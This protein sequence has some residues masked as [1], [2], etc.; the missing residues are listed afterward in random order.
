VSEV[1]TRKSLQALVDAWLGQGNIAAGPTFVK[2]D[3]CMYQTLA[4]GESLALDGFVHP[5]NSIKEFFFPRNE[6]IYAYRFKGQKIELEDVDPPSTPRLIIGVR[7]CDAASMAILDRVFNW[8][9]KDKFYNVRREAATIVS[10]GCA[11][12]DANCFCTSVGLGPVAEKGSDAMLFPLGGDEFEVR[13]FAEKGKAL[14]A[15]KTQTSSKEFKAAAGPEARVDVEL[16]AAQLERN[17]EDPAWREIALRCLGCGACAYTCPTCHCFDIV[18]E[19]N[20]AGGAR[21][22]NWDS[23]QFSMFTLHASGHNPRG[24]QGQRQRQRIQHKFRIY[25]QKFND[26]LCTGC[27]NCTRNCPVGLGVLNTL[28]DLREHALREA[29]EARG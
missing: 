24:T 5:A 9:F 29:N 17:F 11:E 14:F 4:S 19:G 20:A 1:I 26:I 16:I 25:P 23:C 22:K 21:I 2:P 27:G 6:P 12:H 15:G 13:C 28:V 8:D 10:L 3:T 7:P 18:D